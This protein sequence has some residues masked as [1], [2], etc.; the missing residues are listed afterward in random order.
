MPV[1]EYRSMLRHS[2]PILSPLLVI[3][4]CSKPA[5]VAGDGPLEVVD[6]EPT[7]EITSVDDPQEQRRALALSGVLPDRFPDGLPL[8]LPASV[9]DISTASEDQ[10]AVT[11]ML[12]QP[13]STVEEAQ[14][15]LLRSA[16]WTISPEANGGWLLARGEVRVRMAI[17]RGDVGTQLRFEY[18]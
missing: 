18:R 9:V 6:V 16:G 3:V 4:A 15:E 10:Q 2:L 7:V 8:H 13:P 12:D 17:K 1:F 5:P 11:L 14:L